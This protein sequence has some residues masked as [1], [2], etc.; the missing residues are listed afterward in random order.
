MA[1]LSRRVATRYGMAASEF[2]AEAGCLPARIT[3]PG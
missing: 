1:M 3:S 2:A